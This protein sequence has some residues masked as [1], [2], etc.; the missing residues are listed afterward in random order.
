[1]PI[2]RTAQYLKGI[3]AVVRGCWT[4]ALNLGQAIAQMGDVTKRYFR[5][6]FY[7]GAKECGILEDEVTIDEK[8]TFANRLTTELVYIPGFMHDVYDGRKAGAG[9]QRPENERPLA[10]FFQRAEMW[11]NRYTQVLDLGKTLACKD[12]KLMWVLNPAK[13]NCITCQKLNGKV[14]RASQW[15]AAR[16]DG[17][18]PG[19]P[20]LACGGYRCG[21]VLQPTDEPLSK[22]RLP[23][24]P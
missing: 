22:G 3:R 12:R 18:Y 1:M 7:D 4:G 16:A 8:L 6:A 21:C 15:Q 5:I 2:D 9:D 11:A 14:K 20:H 13:E 10:V 19:S 23:S 24:V 17:I